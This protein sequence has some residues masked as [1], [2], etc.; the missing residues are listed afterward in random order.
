VLFRGGAHIVGWTGELPKP[1]TFITKNVAGHPV[2]VT[3]AD[4]GVLRAF[5][6]A[7]THRGAQVADGCGEARR[8]TCPY[9]AW[10][11]ELNG[12]V[13]GQPQAYAF[14]DIEKSSLGLQPLPIADVAGL[15]AVGLSDDVDPAAAFADIEPQLRWCGYESH[16][17]V[18]QHTWTLKANWKIAFDVNL[19][20]YHVDYLHRDTLSNLVLHNPIYDSFGKHARWGFPTTGTEKVVDLP[21]EHWPPT[22]PVSIIHT[23]FP[24]VVLLETPV[25]CQMFRVYPGRNVNECTVDLTEASL[26]PIANEEDRDARKRGADFAALVVGTEDFP[27]AEQCQRGA[28]IGLTNFN[29]GSNEPM[30]QHW[31]RTWQHALDNA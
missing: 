19:E 4:D 7:C 27:A 12:D 25:S 28:E 8:L 20:S 3:R 24:S 29:F 10:S 26:K 22:M 14:S 1:G 15:I 5:R 6:N 18:C 17:V 13:A 31:H 30:L 16:E 21:E 2:L 23:L 9:H 11:F